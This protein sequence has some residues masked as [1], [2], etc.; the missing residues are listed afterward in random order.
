MLECRFNKT[1][2]HVIIIIRCHLPSTWWA[3][4]LG[5]IQTGVS[6]GDHFVL[7]I[8]PEDKSLPD[9]I[10]QTGATSVSIKKFYQN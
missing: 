4:L 10:S 1:T 7:V 9:S 6:V 5:F 2:H 3:F 8:D